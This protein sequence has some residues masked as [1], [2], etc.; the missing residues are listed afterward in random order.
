MK[1]MIHIPTSLEEAFQTRLQ[2]NGEYLSGGT[3]VLAGKRHPYDLV[4]LERIPGLSYIE[5]RSGFLEIGSGTTFD[6]L[7]RSTLLKERYTALWSAAHEMAGPQIRNRAT[8]G[9]NIGSD[10]PSADSVTALMALDGKLRIFGMEAGK[11]YRR[12]A[13]IRDFELAP[14]E[15]VEAIMVPSDVKASVF[16]KVGKRN[17]MAV[18]V[19]NMAVART[20]DGISVSVGS[21]GPKVIFCSGTSRILS[22]N[23]SN[24]IAVKKQILEEISPRD[25]RWGTVEQKRM[26]CVKMLEK[27]VGE[28]LR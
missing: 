28:V 15:I 14:G 3:V 23:A 12:V 20:N 9:G 1:Y 27:L 21:A 18:S 22:A 19:I 4:S 24:M 16:E 13:S 26:L 17:A 25:D 11:S 8:I 10:S 6:D 7:D 5:E 2:R